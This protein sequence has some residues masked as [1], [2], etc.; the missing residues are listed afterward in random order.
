MWKHFLTCCLLFLCVCSCSPISTIGSKETSQ[1]IIQNKI[2]FLTLEANKTGSELSFKVLNQQLVDGKIKKTPPITLNVP[3]HL[4]VVFNDINGKAIMQVAIE[5][6]LT[7]SVEVPQE[8]GRFIRQNL[9]LK[10]ASVVL[11]VQ[12][13]KK[14][15]SIS[16]LSE[17]GELISTLK[18][19]L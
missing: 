10:K 14:I 18:V 8:N 1:V 11:R 15:D 19:E 12:Y 16:I 9:D 6:P 3:N 5:N 17:T 13:S 7:K 2:L 4:K